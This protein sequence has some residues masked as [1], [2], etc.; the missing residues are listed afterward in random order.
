LDRIPLPQALVDQARAFES[1]EAVPAEPRHAA[2][3]VLLREGAAGPEVYLLRRQTSMAFAGGM[4][5]FP[6]GGV[7]PRDFDDELVDRG[8][9][10]GPSPAEWASRL[11]CDE[12]KARALVCAAVRET[13]EESGVLLAGAGPDSVVAD[14]TG[15]DW[16]ADRVALESREVSLTAFLEK[17][18]LVLR[19]DLLGAWSGW[20]T[21]VFEPRRYRTW[22]FVARLPEGQVTR[23]VSSESS[24][25]MWAGAMDAVD[26]VE[27]QEMLMMPPT[28][29]TCLDVAQHADPDAVLAEART[30]RVEMYT[31]EVVPDGEGFILSTPPFYAALMASR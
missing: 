24:S 4:C 27:R 23:D 31:P 1:G 22:F 30:R 12:P 11:G 16:E 28:W 5:V 19:T 2:T 17:R 25:V 10:A 18:S 8:L 26:Q 14:T 21:P 29:L 20:L 13:F 3:V 6:G 15:D 7:D 9:W